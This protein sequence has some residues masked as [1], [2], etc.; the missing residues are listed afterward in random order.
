M[1]LSFPE[2]ILI[3]DNKTIKGQM[4]LDQVFGPEAMGDEP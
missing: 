2:Q 1:H 4:Q 3:I